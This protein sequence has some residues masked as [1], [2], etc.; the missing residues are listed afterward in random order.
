MVKKVLRSAEKFSE[1]FPPLSGKPLYP[2]PQLFPLPTL[3]SGL[4]LQVVRL[5]LSACPGGEPHACLTWRPKRGGF[6][7]WTRLSRFFLLFFWETAK[8]RRRAEYGFGEYG[9]KHRT[10]WVF[11][12]SLSSRERTQW[13]P[14]SLL[15]VCQSELTEFFAELTEFAAELSELSPPKQYS[16]NSIL[17]V[18]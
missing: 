3:L 6:P 4:R 10:Q 13:V 14:L 16:R 7:I 17:P 15:F 9:F 12:G 5:R 1:P 2:S 11:R 8:G 18:S